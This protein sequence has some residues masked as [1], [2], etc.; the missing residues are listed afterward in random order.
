M[1]D[2]SVF[3]DLLEFDAAEADS[4]SVAWDRLAKDLDNRADDIVTV[5]RRISGAWEGAAATRAQEHCDGLRKEL[6]AAYVA[7][8]SIA[9]ALRRHADGMGRL[10]DHAHALVAEANQAHI[11][12]VRGGFQIDAGHGDQWSAR[13]LGS[14][15][16]QAE[17]LLAAA[18]KLDRETA[19]VIAEQSAATA[20]GAG[21]TV[22]KDSVPAVGAD[23]ATVKAWWDSL[24]ADQRR[25]VLAEYPELVGNLDGVPATA[26]DVANRIVLDRDADQLR[27]RVDQLNAREQHIRAMVQS[28]QGRQLYPNSDNPVGAA[29]AELE[30]ID[31]ERR[32][33]EGKLKGIA[34]I[35]KRLDD[36]SPGQQ[37]AYLIGFSTADQGRAIVSIGNPD[38]AD[39]VLTYVPGTGAELSKVRGDLAR[40]EYMADDANRI[41]PSKR[42]AAILWLGYDAPDDILPDAAE[43]GYADDARSDLR[44]FQD[45]LRT[46]HDGEPSHNVVLG[47]SYGS[48]VV[49]HTAAGRLDADDL[50]FVGSPGVGVDSARELNING[51]S[52]AHVWASTAK[53]DVIQVAG[54]DDYL[55]HGEN[56]NSAGFGGR[57]FTSDPGT[58]RWD[59]QHPLSYSA[60]AHSDYWVQDSASRNN[61]ALITVGHTGEVR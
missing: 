34:I 54:L 25:F 16:R 15:L 4:A 60:Q 45:G 13:A 2:V 32:A 14:F 52:G 58:P 12:Y 51:D 26:R 5:H 11:S 6:D 38:E 20:G 27:E 42:T 28:G 10:R 1:S 21:A 19:R 18:Q 31:E 55:I 57:M 40:A 46:T 37:A 47:H 36:H 22:A 8:A 39:N 9:Q 23:P 17:E 24:T 29:L 33:D 3:A 59:W 44:R 48:T 35:N 53:N 41:D 7:V 43:R 50:I 49:G 61:I 56:P 30:R